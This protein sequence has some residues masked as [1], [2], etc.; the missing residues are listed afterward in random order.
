MRYGPI[1]IEDVYDGQMYHHHFDADGF[2]KGTQESK[3]K[4]GK[5]I[6]FQLNT[7]GV[8]IFKSSKMSVWP[9]YLTINE[10]PPHLR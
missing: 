9:V 10:L 8:A 5:H 1:W 7:D 3:K 6:S 2:F 4:K